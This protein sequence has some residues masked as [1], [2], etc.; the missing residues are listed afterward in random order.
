[1][2][3]SRETINATVLTSA[4][5]IY[6]RFEADVGAFI[7]RDDG[8][9]RIAKKLRRSTRPFSWR[10]VAMRRRFLARIDIDN[11]RVVKI[12]M[13]FFE[14][15]GRIA[16]SAAT[17]GLGRFSRVQRFAV[18]AVKSFPSPKIMLWHVISSLEH[19]TLSS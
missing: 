15:I 14:A 1:M 4:I 13:K 9:G 3:R 18:L 10:A 16:R 5:G 12:D 7:P 19:I 2:H 17:S 11:I 8:F 6:A